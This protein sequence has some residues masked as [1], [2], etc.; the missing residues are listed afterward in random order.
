MIEVEAR[1][2]KWG[3][4]FGVIIPMKKIKES[5][6]KEG[7]ELDLIIYKKKNPF[8]ETFGILKKS[9]IPTK[10]ILKEIDKESWDE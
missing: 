5:N 1:L 7:E 10:K 8:V 2:R 9:K 3:R 6:L 4:S